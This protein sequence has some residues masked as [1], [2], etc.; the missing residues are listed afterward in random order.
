VLPTAGN[1]GLSIIEGRVGTL[2]NLGQAIIRDSSEWTHAFIVL[3]DETVIEAMPGGAIIVP[4]SKYTDTSKR[5]LF[6]NIP[7]TDEQRRAIVNVARAM[8][9]TPYSFLDYVSLAFHHWGIDIKPLR[10]HIKNKGHMICSQLVDFCY[11]AAG[12]H[13]FSDGRW[14]QDVSPGSLSRVLYDNNW[15]MPVRS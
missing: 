10:T 7:L 9:G 2:V 5:V 8:E 14:S 11:Q 4:L 3:D 15:D 13:L 12:V 6:S 1:F